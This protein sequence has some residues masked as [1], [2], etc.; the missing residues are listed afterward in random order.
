MKS[1][2][3]RIFSILAIMGL[4]ATACTGRA[5]C[6]IRARHAS[7]SSP[8]SSSSPPTGGEPIVVGA[9]LPLTGDGASYGPG[10]EAAIRIAIDEVNA[11]GGRPWQAA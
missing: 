8:A 7:T 11:A 5:P 10:M 1:R 2:G 4:A 6:R 9:L 3:S